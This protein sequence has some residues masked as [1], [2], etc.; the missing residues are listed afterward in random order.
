MNFFNLLRRVSLKHIRHQK[1]RTII[2][3]FGIALGVASM[4]SIDIVNSSVIRSLEDSINRITGRAVLQVTGAE[5]GFPESLLERVQ[6]VPGV[7]YAVPMIETNANLAAGSERSF[8]VLGVDVLQDNK[9]RDYSVT[10]ESADI[11]DPLLFLAKPDSILLTR[12]MAKREGIAIDQKIQVQTVQGL[13]TF[14]VRGLL[15]PD[16]PAKALGGDIAIMDIYAAQLAFGKEGRI[17]RIDV[18]TLRGETLDT[19]KARIQAVL[20]E[21]YNID[22]PAG[23]TRQIENLMARFRKSMDLISFMAL[24]VGMYLIYNTVSISVV[25]RREIGILRALGT[26]QGQIIRLFLAETVVISVIASLLGVFLGLALAKLS[27]TAVAQTVSSMYARSEVTE[28]EFSRLNL[29]KDVCI[30]VFASIIA[31]AFPAR[32]STRIV[33][34]SAIRSLPYSAD[35]HLLNRT[36][37][38][39][40]ACFMLLAGVVII[41]YKS[42]GPA[43]S[44]RNSTT[45]TAAMIFLLLGIS[46]ATPLFLRWFIQAFR[47]FLAARLGAGGRLAGLNLQK[48]LSRNAVAVAAVFFSI[49]LSVSSASMINSARRGLRDYIDSVERSDIIITSGHPL[50]SA[51]APT[52]PMPLSMARELEAVPGVQSAD[53]FR[54]LFLNISGKRVLLE[55]IDELRW[56]KHNTCTITEGRREDLSAKMPGQDNVVVNEIVAA[57]MGLKPGDSIVLPTPDGPKRFGVVAII[58]SY[59]SDSGVIVM[60]YRT[61]ERH[62]RDNVADMF[63]VY[64]KPGS[65][66]PA[67]RAAIQDRFRNKR[68]MFVLPSLEFRAE[69]KKLLD[70]SFVMNDAVNVL[71]LVIAGFGIVVTLLA[72]VLER[73]REIG[74]LRAIGMKRSQV[75]A[76]VII[77]SALLGMAGGLLGS[78][79]G[80]LIGWI[81]LEGFF[82]IDFGSSITYHIHYGSIAWALLLAIG[83]AVLAGLYPA[84]RAAKTNITEAL[85][86]E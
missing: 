15:E 70:R 2:A 27:I 83:L 66:I 46:L 21:G 37:K 57:R 22:T 24:F 72:S 58:V 86:Y 49:S 80:V 13:K 18:S 12:E 32:S 41:I 10:D 48:N 38:I 71:T 63:S 85:S 5:S 3:I 36:L 30:G 29:L 52:I 11:P 16:G 7:E 69:I 68:K 39:L 35:A 56:T 34:V 79:A 6:A 42:V 45:T 25:Q 17:D 59:A 77:E 43:S 1:A 61:Y 28:L 26:T 60:D 50:A 76:V 44:I 54:K 64:V 67:V 75:S 20:P 74:I 51:G 33:P 47:C 31:A 62:W 53:P 73:T 8:V 84:R 82:R 4:T 9:V 40:S 23:R 65:D 81:N 19:M 78:A 14:T 55:I